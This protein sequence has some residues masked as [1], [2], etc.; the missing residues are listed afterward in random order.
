MIN[1]SIDRKKSNSQLSKPV[2][3]PSNS[4]LPS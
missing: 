1:T 2:L 4:T 3:L